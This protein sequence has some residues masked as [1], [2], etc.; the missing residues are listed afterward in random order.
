MASGGKRIQAGQD[1]RLIDIA[2]DGQ[3]FGAFD[4]LH[5]ETEARHF[6]E[7]LQRAAA[8]HHGHPG[9]LFVERFR[10]KIDRS[11]AYTSFVNE[12]LR[13]AVKIHDLDRDSQ[14]QRSLKRFA[15]AALAGEMATIFGLTGWKKGTA[16]N[17]ILAVAGAWIEDK[18]AIRKR[19]ID[20]A[21]DRT[22]AH[23]TAHLES[24]AALGPIESVS[25]WRDDSFFYIRPDAWT[26]IHGADEAQGAA[27]LH[28]AAGFLRT[29]RG[30]TLQLRLGRDIPGRPKV[31]AVSVALLKEQ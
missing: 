16:L 3:V 25:G 7:R 4:H 23:L 5:G 30:K 28:E 24:F 19:D 14:V 26:Q 29:D 13:L 22:R 8:N 6:V 10:S 31:Y 21:L 15:L 11:D 27:R 12:F 17:G 2:A 20:A 1:I 18:G 9:R